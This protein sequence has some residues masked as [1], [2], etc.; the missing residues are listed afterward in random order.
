MK[1]NWNKSTDKETGTMLSIK[2]PFTFEFLGLDARDA[3]S[4]SII[5]LILFFI[6]GFYIAML[7]LNERM[8][9]SNMRI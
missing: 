5:L 9:S 6:I 1:C 2:G 3:V 7:L 4:I 8:M